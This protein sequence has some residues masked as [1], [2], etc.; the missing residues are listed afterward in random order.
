MLPPV[1]PSGRPPVEKVARSAS[2]NVRMTPA[3]QAT[4][5]RIAAEDGASESET[6]RRLIAEEAKRRPSSRKGK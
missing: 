1:S 6:V 4:L 5:R 3:L 2:V